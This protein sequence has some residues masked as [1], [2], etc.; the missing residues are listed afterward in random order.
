[1]KITA[2]K[3]Q[4]K[5]PGRYSIFV[6]EKYSFSLSDIA[7]LDQKLTIGLE[8]SSEQLA[9]LKQLSADDKAYNRVLGYLAVRPRSSFEVRQYLR[10]KQAT[11][12]LT[13]AIITK[14]QEKRLLDD[15][16]FARSWVENRRLLKPISRRKLQVELRQKGVSDQIVQAVLSDDE[17]EDISVLKEL[18]ERKRRQTKYQDQTK[19]MQY[20]ARQGF[21]Y[22][23]IKRALETDE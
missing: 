15:E 21:M 10:R 1:M 20:L 12:E 3:A 17:T 13:E 5:R 14:L 22:E 18:V 11:A 2:I 9:A 16:A 4:V 19:L 6:D 7:L 23:D 8:L